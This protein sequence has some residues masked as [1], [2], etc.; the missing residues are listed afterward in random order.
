MSAIG[1]SDIADGC[2]P[3]SVGASESEEAYHLVIAFL[4]SW[5]WP[6]QNMVL[7]L[8]LETRQGI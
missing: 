5:V 4:G 2:G 6:K 8:G 7:S 1:A 3:D